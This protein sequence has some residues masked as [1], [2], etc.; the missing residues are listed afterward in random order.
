M[1]VILDTNL[2]S[3]IGDEQVASQFNDLVRSRSLEVLVPPSTLVEVVR[4][5]VAPVR[6][7]IIGALATGP[8]RRL[9]T[10][11]E[12]EAAELVTEVRRVRPHWMRQMPDT[13][14]VATLT[15]RWTKGIWREALEDAQ[16][17]HDYEMRRTSELEYLVNRQ[18]QQRARILH[19]K[20]SLR[21]L[22][23]LTIT[24]KPSVPES[25]LAGWSGSKVEPWRIAARDL[26]WHQL[27]VV[28]GR[29]IV[30]KEDTT[31]ADWVSAYVRLD[32]LRSDQ[33]DFTRFWLE[34]VNLQA[35]PRHWLRWAVNILQADHKVTHGN[36]ADEQHSSYLV[37]GDLFLSAD[38]RYV[39]V[40]EAVRADAPFAMAEPR[41]VP[42]D[43]SIPV[44]DRIVSVL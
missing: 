25:Y 39:Y 28:A 35:M 33:R 16:R 30:T 20:F 40:L 26:Y 4:L 23:A 22:T 3:S 17:L 37:E 24:A 36:P 38:A 11:A 13:A 18:R 42:G 9:R 14:R 19:T 2:W 29:A 1:R 44:L 27:V 6:Q 21:P 8:R 7:R 10:E 34:D 15:T 5:P 41:L 43:R 31:F 32:A 12:S